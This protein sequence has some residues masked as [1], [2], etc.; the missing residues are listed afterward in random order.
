MVCLVPTELELILGA[1]NSFGGNSDLYLELEKEKE[2]WRV[3]S[4]TRVGN[5]VVLVIAN[6]CVLKCVSH[7]PYL[8]YTT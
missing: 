8:I 5:K 7:Y 1:R 3:Y 4:I 6:I 2:N